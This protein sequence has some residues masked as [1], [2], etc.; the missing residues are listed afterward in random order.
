MPSHGQNK[1]RTVIWNVSAHFI[2]TKIK[3]HWWKISKGCIHACQK[4]HLLKDLI[5]ALFR[6]N[7]NLNYDFLMLTNGQCL[8][9]NHHESKVH[10]TLIMNSSPQ[11]L[12]VCFSRSTVSTEV[13]KENFQ[14]LIRMQLLCSPL[15]ALLKFEITQYF[16]NSYN[17]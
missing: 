9:L 14:I 7:F 1:E 10:M 3:S 5:L 11:T 6:D 12:P 4:L 16:S 13:T 17:L 15:S 2:V 8:A